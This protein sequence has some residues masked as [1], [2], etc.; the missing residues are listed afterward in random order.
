MNDAMFGVLAWAPFLGCSV[1]GVILV[2]WS[3]DPLCQAGGQDSR[4]LWFG[5]GLRIG[6]R[7]SLGSGWLVFIR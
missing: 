2:L 7:G 3:A 4:L 1:C 5:E 6:C